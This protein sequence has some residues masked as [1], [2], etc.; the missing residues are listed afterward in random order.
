[1]QL[2]QLGLAL[3]VTTLSAFS[4]EM[5]IEEVS[6]RLRDG[7]QLHQEAKDRATQLLGFVNGD[8]YLQMYVRPL[9]LSDEGSLVEISSAK[10]VK[11]YDFPIPTDLKWNI[12]ETIKD[13]VSANIAVSRSKNFD[14]VIVARGSTAE[15]TSQI[16]SEALSGIAL[17]TKSTRSLTG[18]DYSGKKYY[19]G[20]GDYLSGSMGNE[21]KYDIAHTHDIF[22]KEIGGNYLGA[23]IHGS[24]IEE[25]DLTKKWIELKKLMTEKDMFVQYS[26]GHGS[27]T[28]LMFGPTYN[29]IRD[30]ALSYPSKEI[31]IFT[32]SCYS[33]NLV[34]SFNKKKL[35]WQDWQ[36]KGRT[37]M[38][39]S[40][41]R[42][43]ETS[44]TGP[45]TDSEEPEGPNGSA[46]SAFGHALWKSLIGH[47]DGAV[48]GIKD[49]LI[50]LAELRD[51]TIKIT[52]EVGGHT[53][54][55]T[56]AYNGNLLMVKVPSQAFVDSLS[57]GTEK[58][59]ND[60]ILEKI[61]ALDAQWHL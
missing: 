15:M 52:E 43:S 26:S 33:G 21:V 34:E 2:R 48:D 16:L 50:S 28:G 32:M 38:V 3:C 27:T 24:E 45:G 58:L 20:F 60:Q 59:S 14:Y 36:S 55:I 29:E 37:L 17:L 54:T 9:S 19:V 47:A 5:K 10:V 18:P 53:P 12:K 39:M 6:L 42:A 7:W 1:M 35:E 51:H 56:G 25:V 44:S 4:L 49:H 57:G 46:G 13:T 41:S 40:S 8:N 11:Q 23:K 30:N 61:R 31:I 22:T